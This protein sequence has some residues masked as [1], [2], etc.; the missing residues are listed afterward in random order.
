MT[1]IAT[2]VLG[3]IHALDGVERTLTSP[4]VPSNLIGMG[5]AA[6]S[7]PSLMP[8]EACYVHVRAQ[9]GAVEGLVERIAEIEEVSGVA[10]T[11]GPFDLVVEIRHPWEVA[12]GTVLSQIQGIP[13]IVSTTTML[14]VDY[15][16]REEDRDQFSPWS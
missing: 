6:P 12:A 7:P 11:G 13:G 2:T 8:G 4:L 5:F 14:G 9:A 3:E 1:A 16:E 10:A 15:D